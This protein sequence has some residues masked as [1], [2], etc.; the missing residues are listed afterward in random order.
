MIRHGEILQSINRS[1]RSEWTAKKAALQHHQLLIS[2]FSQRP[3]DNV[4]SHGA[5]KGFFFDHHYGLEWR[6][7]L[8][9]M[10]SEEIYGS[11]GGRKIISS[12]K[13]TFFFVLFLTL[14]RGNRRHAGHHPAVIH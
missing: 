2:H 1:D 11:R 10:G 14:R 8:R 6:K 7:V 12:R 13:F 4:T 9:R 3:A 5:Q